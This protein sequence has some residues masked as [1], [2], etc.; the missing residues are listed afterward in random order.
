VERNLLPGVQPG[1]INSAAVPEKA[2]QE[3]A[4]TIRVCHIVSG[5]LWAGAEVQAASL[6]RALAS[7]PGLSLTVILLNQGRLAEELGACGLE[8]KV[9]PENAKSFIQIFREAARFLRSRNIE[10]L[11]SHRYKENLL[12]V[13][14][15][16]T[17]HIPHIVRT[18][19]GLPEP[20]EGIK[21]IRQ[22]LMSGLDR[23]VARHATDR[24]ISVSSE[25]RGHLSRYVDPRKVVVIPNGL[26]IRRVSTSLSPTEARERLGIP[27]DAPTIGYAGRL[28]PVKR[29]D[30][31]LAAAQLVVRQI[32]SAKFLIVGDGSEESRLRELARAGGL[33]D[34][35][36][37][38]G[39]RDDIYDVLRAMEIFVL[40]SD[41]EGLPMVLLEALHLGVPVVGRRVGGLPEV[42][43]DGVNG[44]LVS[45]DK[46]AD[47][48][49]GCLRLLE[50]EGLRQ[51]LTLAARKVVREKFSAESNA[52]RVA[53]L[54]EELCGIQRAS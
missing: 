43:Q 10:I 6:L 46:P 32:P 15:A 19:H 41:H 2:R 25:L 27:A 33:R 24:V 44:I 28:E 3:L 48:A 7:R 16:R 36:M 47:F 53:A 18:Q 26:D 4:N 23:F 54:Y 30:L 14:L 40:C 49:Q 35:V 5:D 22:R 52:A 11:H 20:F 9:I 17:C 8:L 45:S 39:H 21:H 42:I 50:D 37:F 34:S 29:L 13:L 51:R 1:A 12:A 31:F 38:L